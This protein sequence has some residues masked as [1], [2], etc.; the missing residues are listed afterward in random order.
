MVGALL[1]C[2]TASLPDSE[3]LAIRGRAIRGSPD[4]FTPLGQLLRNGT[5]VLFR[6]DCFARNEL[7]VLGPLAGSDPLTE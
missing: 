1:R 6:K 4:E 7:Y 5:D 2:C 3:A